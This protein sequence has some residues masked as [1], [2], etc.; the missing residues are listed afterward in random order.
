MDGITG[1]NIHEEIV[2]VCA[3]NIKNSGIPTT[4]IFIKFNY[5]P[6]V[7]DF[8][9]LIDAIFKTLPQNKRAALLH[10]IPPLSHQVIKEKKEELIR[11]AYRVSLLS[12]AGAAIPL[13]PPLGICVD[14]PILHL[15]IRFYMNEFSLTE[16]KVKYTCDMLKIDY[17]ELL[18]KLPQVRHLLVEGI[19]GIVIAAIAL[20][21]AEKNTEVIAKRLLK[22]IPVVGT[23]I[24][25]SIAYITCLKILHKE[26]DK[27]EKEAHTLLDK[28]I[29]NLKI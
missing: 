7:S 10:S 9:K 5:D 19:K 18:S 29:E 24:S 23:I 26:I 4:S 15:E 25:S 17:Q 12:A 21:L 28:V 22:F 27:L 8:D 11:R 13:P 1:E 6:S 2:T 20:E 14:L 3:K 16:D